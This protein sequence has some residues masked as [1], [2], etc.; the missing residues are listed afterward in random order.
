MDIDAINPATVSQ[1][2][3]NEPAQQVALKRQANQQQAPASSEEESKSHSEELLKQIKA[4]TEDGTYNVSFSKDSNTN[5]MVVNIIDS[6][7]NKIIRQI[8]SESALILNKSLSELKGNI[9]NTVS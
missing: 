9:V 4:I 5:Q 7:T 6:K 2:R 1:P 8:P 3:I